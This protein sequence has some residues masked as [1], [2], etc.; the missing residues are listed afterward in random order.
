MAVVV[1]V[2]EEKAAV[3]GPVCLPVSTFTTVSKHVHPNLYLSLSL[4]SL[5]LST[6]APS[7]FLKQQ[8]PPFTA[9]TVPFFTWF[10]FYRRAGPFSP[11][12]GGRERR[13]SGL[14]AAHPQQLSW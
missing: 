5:L 6:P 13:R 11:P 1:A 9:V 7:L 3:L 8:Y 4:F 12:M 10:C 2:E 14:S